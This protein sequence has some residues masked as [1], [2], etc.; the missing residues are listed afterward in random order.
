MEPGTNDN[1]IEKEGRV[2]DNKQG[3]NKARFKK[4]K[5]KPWL[6]KMWCI[7]EINAEYRKRMYDIIDLYLEPYDPKRPKIGVDE[8]SKQLLKHTI[9]PIPMRPGNS[10]KYDYE[11]GRN[12]TSNIF[13][14]IEPDAGWRKT[15]VTK[16][17]TKIDFAHFVKELV[18]EDYKDAELIRLIVDN[19]NTHFE[20]F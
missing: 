5:T 2:W 17:R 4:S 16:R 1:G 6:K 18:D 12:G 20:S 15:K 8:K 3:I 10:G 7:G 14:A 9:E 11:Y 19:L 13:V